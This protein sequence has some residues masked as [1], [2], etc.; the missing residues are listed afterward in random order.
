MK[1]IENPILDYIKK[2]YLFISVVFLIVVLILNIYL[3]GFI[4][5]K[6]VIS[7][8]G[9]LK[10]SAFPLPPPV[11]E[12]KMLLA[13]TVGE[14]DDSAPAPPPLN[15]PGLSLILQPLSRR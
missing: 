1:T 8:G 14:G 6:K 4:G 5:I 12:D 10:T 2:R 9:V 13:G 7:V 15:F 3:M 11:P